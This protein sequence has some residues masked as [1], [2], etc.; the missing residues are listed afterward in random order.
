MQQAVLTLVGPASGELIRYQ[1]EKY[2]PSATQF[3]LETPPVLGQPL[4]QFEF[5]FR[6]RTQAVD[7]S[8]A[9]SSRSDNRPREVPFYYLICIIPWDT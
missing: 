1:E 6:S 7:V 8:E 9:A 4:Y 2:Q 3:L 5:G